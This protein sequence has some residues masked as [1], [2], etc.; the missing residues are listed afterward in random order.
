VSR[1]DR[2]RH[3]FAVFLA[4]A[5]IGL[6][7]AGALVKSREAG[8]SVPDW[9]LSYGSLNPP[10]WWQI[11]NVRAEHGHRLIA[12]TVAL[13]TIGLA[14]WSARGETRAWVRRIS[15]L[16]VVAVL[17]QAL[18]G[19]ITVLFF[20]PT[21]IS[22]SHAGLAQI[23][24]CLIVTLAVTTSRWWHRER[25]PRP[26]WTGLRT[27][28]TTTTGLV[29]CQILIGAVM[30]HSGA[31]LA[32]PDFP[33][34]F[35]RLIPPR[36]D[37][38]IGIHFTHR[39]GALFV[40]AAIVWLFLRVRRSGAKEP[41]LVV[42]TRVLLG[43]VLIQIGL[44]AAVVLTGK[45]VVLNTVH[46]TTGAAILATSMVATLVSWRRVGRVTSV[47]EIAPAASV[48]LQGAGS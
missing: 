10:R 29:Y 5:V 39:L 35:G 27:A 20:L 3:R 31:G 37:F 26:E 21:A 23:F 36:F 6:I 30:R 8:L 19:G 41:G 16:A 15:Y 18:L 22:V 47:V 32:I 1:S 42:P 28:A 13:L 17:A 33:L 4:L 34:A 12:G 9:P 11:A 43:L 14:I 24:L 44:G 25:S 46:V 2:Y 7:S 48:E 45:A 40:A 38:A